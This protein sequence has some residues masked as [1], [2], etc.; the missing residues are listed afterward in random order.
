LASSRTP[1]WLDDV[2]CSSST[3]DLLS[4]NHRDIG[5]H[6]CSHS[7][8]VILKCLSLSL[9]LEIP[10]ASSGD[11]RLVDSRGSS[12]TFTPSGRLEIFINGAWRTVC[13]NN[14]DF[15]EADIACRELG[16]FH[17]DRVG[18]VGELG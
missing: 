1:V 12:F 5:V 17:A 18:T 8:D 2:V 4:C 6:N 11:V 14:F 16:F 9:E 15:H 10:P 7:D 3:R 13:A